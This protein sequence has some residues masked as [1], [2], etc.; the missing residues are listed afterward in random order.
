MTPPDGPLR[1]AS[2][3]VWGWWDDW[4]A[5]LEVLAETWPADDPDVLLL[6]EVVWTRDRERDQL[7]EIASRLGYEYLARAEGHHSDDAVEGVAIASRVPLLDPRV[8]EL[9]PTEPSRRVCAADVEAGGVRIG[10]MSAHTVPTPEAD[11]MDQV[12]A[13]LSLPETPCVVGADLNEPPATVHPL[14]DAVGL[15]D[16]LSDNLAPTWPMQPEAFERAWMAKIGRAPHFSLEPRRLDYLL[17]RGLHVL[18]NEVVTL[19]SGERYASDH[20]LV[21][22]SSS[23]QDGSARRAG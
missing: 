22:A 13:V 15:V 7:V 16:A 6:Q 19:R 14:L 12:H 1:I 3:N 8:V 5:R 17:S 23:A 21:M 2:L 11:R 20:A 9:P 18:D 4:P 10:V